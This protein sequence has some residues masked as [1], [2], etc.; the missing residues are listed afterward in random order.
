MSRAFVKE[1][2]GDFQPTRAFGLPPVED[3]SYDAACTLVLLEAARDGHVDEAERATG[4]RFGDAHLK[5][6]VQALL[7]KELARDEEGR[8]RRFVGLAR[9]WLRS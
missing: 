5:P 7:D 3:P 6:H 8:D 2:G 4:Y 1:D 9:R